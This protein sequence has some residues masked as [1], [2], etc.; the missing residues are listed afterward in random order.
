MYQNIFVTSRTEF[1]D[2]TVYLWDDVKGLIISPY[3]PMFG[4]AYRRSGMGR[5]TSIYG[6]KLVKVNR[7][8][9]DDP[10]LFESDLARETRVLTDLYLDSDMPSTGHRIACIDIEVSSEGGFA[11][12]ETAEN[13]I[14]AISLY[15]YTR[16]H[17]T[18]FL[19]DTEQQFHTQTHENETVVSC[20]TEYELI[21]KFLKWY[22]EYAP[23]ILTG[24]NIDG[25][26][27]PYMYNRL[28]RVLGAN[29][30]NKLSPVG[31]VKYS[32]YRN[33]YALAGV[34]CLDY[35]T[36]Y[37]KFIGKI[38]PS[39]RLD[40]IGKTEIDLGKVEYEGSL[41]QL[42]KNDLGTFLDYTLNDVKIV[43]GLDRKLKYIDLARFV[44][45]AGHVP[46][47]DFS[48]SS[49][50][51]E[52]TIVTYLHRKG[53][54][55]NNKPIDGKA[56]MAAKM[57]SDEDGFIGAYVRP[58][59]PGLYDWI[60][61]LDLTSLY[62]SIIMSLN[63]SPDTKFGR[64]YNWDVDKHIRKEIHE[65]ELQIGGN[66]V[67]HVSRSEFLS[68]IQDNKLTISS[69][70]ILYSCK[71]S[72]ILPEII[73]QWFQDRVEFKSLMKKHL[74]DGNKEQEEFYDRRQYV[75]KI[76]LNSIY[77]V[78][79]L[80]IFRFY[81]LDNAAA[82]TLTGQD[83]IKTTAKFVNSQYKAMGAAPKTDQQVA[84][85]WAVLK[86]FAKKDK[87]AEPPKPAHD[88]HCVYIDTDSVYFSAAPVMQGTDPK[89]FT[90]Q[91]ATDMEASINKFYDSM[92]KM[93][94]NCDK[95]RF[96]I[97]GESVAE[98]GL[99]V[100]KK[101]Y[102]LKRVYNL[103]TGQTEDGK[104]AKVTGLDT[105]RSSFPPAF[106]NFMK[107]LLMDILNK[108]PKEEIDVDI[109][110][111]RTQVRG[112][113]Y[114]AVAR[115]TS[116]NNLY[117]FEDSTVTDLTTFPKGATAHAKAAMVYNRMLRNNGWDS[118]YG[119]IVNGDKIKYVYLKKNPYKLETMAVKTYN[120]PPEIIELV[121]KYIDYDKLF[122]KELE[123]K[124]DNFYSALGW[125]KLPTE[126]NQLAMD[127]FDFE[128]V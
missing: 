110:N 11:K 93:L 62:P 29:T 114:L 78:L 41:D 54:I 99:W 55:P 104:K 7:F 92:A 8:K 86:K 46:Y 39:Y 128:T 117:K 14:T 32:E 66:T 16:D 76:L 42:F 75:Q 2:A 96:Q 19:L 67:R 33:R 12:P 105:Q 1:S 37:K 59:L 118:K 82:V 10:E 98:T 111:F 73:D 24:W 74:K 28:K 68:Y 97:K 91:L 88:D 27:I 120:D 4:Y 23:T 58:P 87:E 101:R 43:V 77:G 122:E 83:V 85:Y 20:P 31:L 94:F 123:N 26:D 18:V 69:N 116:I 113:P 79:G 115:N 52:G 106:S 35:L 127:F 53:I 38:Q 89:A 21:T 126:I 51:I 80:P 44:C 60:Y 13:S 40:A 57:D 47:E 100:A 50:F 15:A 49:K 48:Y 72:G 3:K 124:L 6:D 70:G 63:I 81:D 95:H 9:P 25:Y 109:L 56:Q 119:L 103:E 36:L 107:G 22:E 121:E 84:A 45:H 17:Y 71:R 5:H 34:S 102:A 90:I 112:M 65:Y 61:S 30:A 125:G 64:I 108:K